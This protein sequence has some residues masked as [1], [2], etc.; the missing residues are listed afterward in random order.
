MFLIGLSKDL[1]VQ[2]V[3]EIIK[4]ENDDSLHIKDLVLND[5]II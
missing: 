3:G 1:H 5:M 2:H 4:L